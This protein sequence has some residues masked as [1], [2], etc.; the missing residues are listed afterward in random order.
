MDYVEAQRNAGHVKLFP[1]AGVKNRGQ[2]G[3]NV[4]AWFI[5]GIRS[6]GMESEK[7]VF[8]SLR[9]TFEDR[10]RE[11]DLHGTPLGE[12][13]A[14]RSVAGTSAN[15]GKGYSTAKLKEAIER[16]HYPTVNL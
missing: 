16:V 3:Y 1:D 14:G 6:L 15:Y 13:I 5:K 10:L 9:H 4:G 12:Y 11:A 7:L 8:H 2:A